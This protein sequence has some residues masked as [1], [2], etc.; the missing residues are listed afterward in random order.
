MEPRG[1]EPSAAQTTLTATKGPSRGSSQSV[2]IGR[3]VPSADLSLSIITRGRDCFRP[4]A[5]T[6]IGF[7]CKAPIRQ[8]VVA[9][10]EV[11]AK[12]R[13]IPISKPALVSKTLSGMVALPNTKSKSSSPHGPTSCHCAKQESPFP[14]ISTQ[15]FFKRG[16]MLGRYQGI[17]RA[18][19]FRLLA[20]VNSP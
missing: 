7:V 15:R 17:R 13:E 19:I 2:V 12:P 20:S 3:L 8:F 11:S 18:E 14:L 1:C 5:F 4:R 6:N 10:S 9:H 16:E